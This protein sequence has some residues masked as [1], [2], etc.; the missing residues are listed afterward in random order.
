MLAVRPLPGKNRIKR[1][2]PK[3][4]ARLERK[5]LRLKKQIKQEGPS[6]ELQREL[7]TTKK[8]HRSLERCNA[9][10][11]V[12]QFDRPLHDRFA[13]VPG[14]SRSLNLEISA[15]CAAPLRYELL[16][17]PQAPALL[18]GSLPQPQ[19]S[20]PD[21]EG[22]RT[23]LVYRACAPVFGTTE[24][25]SD[26]ITVQLEGCYV[27][28]TTR[29]INV[30]EHQANSGS[31]HAAN[32]CG[33]T[34]HFEV[35]TEPAHGELD[36]SSAGDYQYEI[37]FFAGRDHFTYRACDVGGAGCSA[38]APVTV[39]VHPA[40]SFTG[41]E[42]TLTA[43]REHLSAEERVH[44]IRKLS[45][46]AR[47]LLEDGGATMPLSELLDSR[48]LNVD[49]ISRDLRAELESVR[50]F[51]FL[52]EV[53]ANDDEY[54]VIPN[55]SPPP[56]GELTELFLPEESFE[57]ENAQREGLARYI[58]VASRDYHP[59]LYKYYWSHKY[60]SQNL[61]LESRY[62]SP[63]RAFMTHLWYGHFGS[64]SSKITGHSEHLTGHY[65][66][67]LQR[68]A[69]GN[70]RRLLTGEGPNGCRSEGAPG[71]IC[72]A[73]TAIYLD[74]HLNTKNNPNENKAREVF[75]L[76]LAGPI[77]F[78]TGLANYSDVQDVRGSAAF[79]S[80]Y[81]MYPSVSGELIFDSSRHDYNPKTLFSELG[82]IYPQLVINNETLTARAFINRILDEHPAVARFIAGK[83]FGMLVY[84]DPSAAVVEEA[85]QILV[86]LDYD[87]GRFVRTI[88]AS[89]A[90]FSPRA[91]ARNCFSEPQRV[92][93]NLVNGLEL[94]LLLHRGS[95]TT[96]RNKARQ[97]NEV[98]NQGV[99]AGGESVLYYPSVFTYDY[100]GRT[101]GT[102]KDGST[103]WLLPS[104]LLGR[105]TGVI[106][107]I[108]QLE[109]SMQEE[110]TFTH[111]RQR[112]LG[113]DEESQLPGDPAALSVDA[114]LNFFA[115]VFQVPLSSEERARLV[116]YM[117]TK[118]N[119]DGSTYAIEWDP[120]NEALVEEKFAGLAAL[121]SSLPG[122]NFH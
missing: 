91:A 112:I 86:G 110:F 22:F 37:G 94:P 15:T 77:D 47:R 25:C 38:P 59:T 1:Y 30:V 120:M 29:E 98:L 64:A 55:S 96:V 46:N 97:M 17:A 23:Q 43:Y 16:E 10:N 66:H 9:F 65:S 88:A 92:M 75:E 104:N 44:L 50:D 70:F 28:A 78:I 2:E 26:P 100:C 102:A 32:D 48:I 41:D 57:S 5:L 39:V 33:A 117:N 4:T 68:E 95:P 42:E 101:P 51:G 103:I 114:I 73:Y 13:A 7:R 106:R 36:V 81:R 31:L 3:M 89:E 122:A 40:P 21:I 63:A 83:L 108:A 79:L 109:S 72:D 119:P 49:Y 82:E 54:V 53:P 90:M 20:A 99:T 121:F 34:S 14:Q 6:E 76:F 60:A 24:L 45:W 115:A 87:I 71:I 107:A 27:T 105:T 67:M 35:V 18:S 52:F 8:I 11:P 56:A 84:P 116:E 111:L 61:L 74:N 80:G 69:L 85:A 58:A 113:L 93:G 19:F 62:L 118:M 12:C